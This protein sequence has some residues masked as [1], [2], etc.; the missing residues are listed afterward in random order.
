MNEVTH[1]DI[2]RRVEKVEVDIAVLSSQFGRH[3]DDMKTLLKKVDDVKDT[4]I[5][6]LENLRDITEANGNTARQAK[7]LVLAVPS[8]IAGIYTLI[9][10]IEAMHK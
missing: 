2:I 1:S 9:Q 4:T 10:I 7:T 8:V 6:K 5:N 3:N